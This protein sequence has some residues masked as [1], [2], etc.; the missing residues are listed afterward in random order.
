MRIRKILKRILYGLLFTLILF[1][2]WY[3]ELVGYGLQQGY[4][5]L[6]IIW[7]TKPVAEFLADKNFPDSLKTKLKLIEE[8]RKF[9]FD[10]L[11]L[12]SNNNY[13]TVYDTKS[14][15]I[16]WVVTA[17]EPYSFT[18]KEWSFSFLGKMPYKAFFKHE[19][20]LK[21]AD[22]WKKEGLDV[23]VD[24]VSGWSTLG[25]FKDP[26][27]TNMLTRSEGSLSN[28]I[29]H[30]LTHGTLYIKDNANY[31]E[32]LASFVGDQGALLF[33]SYKYGENSTPYQ[34]YE[35]SKKRNE[36]YTNYILKATQRLDS[37][38]KNANFK[39]EADTAKKNLIKYTLIKNI[40]A[41]MYI[42][43]P[44]KTSYKTL[45][46]PLPNN[47]FFMDYIRY[48]AQQNIFE[49][50]FKEQFSSNFKAYLSYLKET[51]PSL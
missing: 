48:K 34:Q 44:S 3:R 28:L 30:E 49:K 35:E 50:E 45:Q 47:A 15:P 5:Q 10:S 26:I 38:Y 23:E 46:K 36:R 8:I 20:A 22:I 40:V 39:I 4:G 33:L 6:K 2:L 21:E 37:L 29:I 25:W 32:N 18:P 41:D 43:F 9:A 7:N 11:G 16:L 27:L 13:T 1:I 14:K 12:T 17:C 51:Y 31:N 19:N 42:A 24:E